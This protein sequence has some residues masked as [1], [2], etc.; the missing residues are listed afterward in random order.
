MALLIQEWSSA[1]LKLSERN[2]VDRDTLPRHR[3]FERL[4][5]AIT[6]ASK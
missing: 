1:P 6:E 2:P 4:E 3:V 5:E